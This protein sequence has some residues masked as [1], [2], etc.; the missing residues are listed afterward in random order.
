M[1]IYI[2]KTC[3]GY[4]MGFS[5]RADFAFK[6]LTDISPDFLK[7]RGLRLLLLDLDNTIAP[8]TVKAPENGVISWAEKLKSEGIELFIV[9]NNRKTERVRSFSKILGINWINK[10]GKP[11]VRGILEA[12]RRCRARPEETALAGD[13]SYTDV[14]GANLAGI[15]PILVEPIS[16]KNPLLAVRYILEL[17]FRAVHKEKYGK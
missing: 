4:F 14:L 9:S 8:Y 16:L 5:P 1:Y 17:P 12:M 2:H 15:T 11:A 10:A 6:K 13:Q 3:G 7:S